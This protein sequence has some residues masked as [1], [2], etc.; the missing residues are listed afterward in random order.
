MPSFRSHHWKFLEIPYLFL[1]SQHEIPYDNRFK[2]YIVEEIDRWP[3]AQV[4]RD[5][6]VKD[7][8]LKITRPSLRLDLEPVTEAPDHGLD[9]I[10]LMQPVPTHVAGQ[11]R[12]WSERAGNAVPDFLVQVVENELLRG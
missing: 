3:A 7:A 8:D 4:N 12:L 1:R 5:Q 9:L 10:V 2:P 11:I 6:V